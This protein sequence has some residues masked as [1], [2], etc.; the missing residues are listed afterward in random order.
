MEEEVEG[1]RL[2]AVYVLITVATIIGFL[3]DVITVYTL[4]R[5]QKLW[6]HH[7]NLYIFHISI[8][9]LMT[10]PC[11]I[12]YFVTTHNSPPKWWEFLFADIIA[13]LIFAQ[14]S[15]MTIMTVDWYIFTFA[16]QK[17]AIFRKYTRTIVISAYLY[18]LITAALN[19]IVMLFWLNYKVLF[20]LLLHI[21]NILISLVLFPIFGAIYL[22]RRKSLPPKTNAVA[23]RISLTR[24]LIWLTSIIATFISELYFEQIEIVHHIAVVFFLFVLISPGLQLILLYC[25]DPNYKDALSLI[26]GCRKTS[27][28]L[29]SGENQEESAEEGTAVYSTSNNHTAS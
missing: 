25:W 5:F 14:L 1:G 15:L 28:Q 19:L 2:N 11:R 17:S 26:F 10:S 6:K 20:S 12:L 3:A 13:S 29:E 22:C 7:Q 4:R 18:V 8:F 9:G 21:G 24:V 23:L 16:P 27:H